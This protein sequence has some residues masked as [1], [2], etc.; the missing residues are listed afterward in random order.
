LLAALPTTVTLANIPVQTSIYF[1]ADG[2]STATPF[3]S[4]AVAFAA[5]NFPNESANQ[6]VAR[7]L[8]GVT[9]VGFLTG[10][11]VTGGRL[12]LSG[13]VDPGANA[14]PDWWESQYF[15][16]VGID[17][18][19]D[20]DGDRFS[21]FQEYLLG[22]APNNPAST[23]TISETAIVQNGDARDFRISF[24]TANGVTYRVEFLDPNVANLW[25]ALGSDLIGTGSPATITDPNAVNLYPSRIYRVRLPAE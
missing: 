19:A 3:V 16:A 25:M 9:P 18:A 22:T 2:T 24:P 12:D 20:P 5:R 1:F 11:V 21:N 8:G 17:P 23:L 6:R 7:I 13:I 14:I 10:K 15:P 4:A